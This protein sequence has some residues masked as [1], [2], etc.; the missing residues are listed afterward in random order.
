[1]NTLTLRDHLTW[2]PLFPTL[3][4]S[5][6]MVSSSTTLGYWRLERQCTDRPSLEDSQEETGLAPGLAGHGSFTWLLLTPYDNAV[7]TN[8]LLLSTPLLLMNCFRLLVLAK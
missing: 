8:G 6:S 5:S 1:M 3:S 4:Q 2:L 7:A